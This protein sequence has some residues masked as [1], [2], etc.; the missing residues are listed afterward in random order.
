MPPRLACAA[1]DAPS[2]ARARSSRVP[3]RR[4]RRARE[5]GLGQP[6]LDR[7]AEEQ[8]LAPRTMGSARLTAPSQLLLR[9]Q[10]TPPSTCHRS[11][12]PTPSRAPAVVAS[13]SQPVRLRESR[14]A[15]RAPRVTAGAEAGV[16]AAVNRDLDLGGGRICREREQTDE[17]GRLENR[18]H[19]LHLQGRRAEGSVALEISQR[20]GRRTR[21]RAVSARTR[22]IVLHLDRET[23]PPRAHASDRC[24]ITACAQRRHRHVDCPS[25]TAWLPAS[26]SPPGPRHPARRLRVRS[27]GELSRWIRRPSIGPGGRR[28]RPVPA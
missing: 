2:T 16:Q 23:A 28:P 5:P 22:P 20:G 4:P 21:P 11:E 19:I 3:P 14:A 18:C 10:A 6:P 24:E 15:A 1:A 17:I 26:A 25:R 8:R 9:D 12:T 27:R 7:A 13:P